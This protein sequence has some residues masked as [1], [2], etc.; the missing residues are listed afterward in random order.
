MYRAVST[1]TLECFISPREDNEMWEK[2][3]I[4]V[5]SFVSLNKQFS[6]KSNITR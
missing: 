6:N 3:K 5:A 2:Y 4:K 1:L